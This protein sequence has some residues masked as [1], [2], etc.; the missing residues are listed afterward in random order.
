MHRDER[1]VPVI[2]RQRGGQF[3]RGAAHLRQMQRHRHLHAGVVVVH[4][5]AEQRRAGKPAHR[6]HFRQ[7]LVVQRQAV[8]A[9]AVQRA[10]AVAG[11]VLGDARLARPGIARQAVHRH[12]QVGGQ[13][14]LLHQRGHRHDEPG[15]V[16]PRHRHAGGGAQLFPGAVQL[17]HAVHPAGGGA[18]G[19][20]GVQHPHMLVDERQDFPCRRVRQAQKRQVA[21]VDGRRTG[22]GILAVG[23]AEGHQRELRPRRQPFPDAQPGGAGGTVNKNFVCH[24]ITQ[25][26]RVLPRFVPARSLCRGRRSLCGPRSRRSGR[27]PQTHPAQKGRCTV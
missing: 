22:G 11:G 12:G 7:V 26:F 14:A 27:W 19:G 16:A 25:F 24:G 8:G 5:G 15:G 21:A 4:H 23:L 20:G 10:A 1:L 6:L 13:K 9:G 18:V 2:V 17:R 3:L